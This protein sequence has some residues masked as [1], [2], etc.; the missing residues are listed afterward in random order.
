MAA[1]VSQ[2]AQ[3]WPEDKFSLFLYGTLLHPAVLKRVIGHEGTGLFHQPALLYDFTRHHVKGDTYPAILPW[4]KADKLFDQ[5][6]AIPKPSPAERC[7]RGSLV[8]G[9]SRVDIELLD[10]FEGD[11]YE[12]QLVSAIPLGPSQP[13]NVAAADAGVVFDPVT[14]P[15]K[16]SEEAIASQTKAHVYVWNKSPLLE[17][18]EPDI[19]SYETFVKENL[20]RWI[21]NEADRSSYTD[22]DRR[23]EKFEAVIREGNVV[24][25]KAA[26]VI[27]REE[28]ATMVDYPGDSNANADANA[29]EEEYKFGHTMLKYWGF[30]QGYINLNNG[31][32]GSPPRPVIEASHKIWEKIEGNPDLFH[33]INMEKELLAVR[34]RIAKFINAAGPDEVVMIPN[35]THGVNTVLHNIHW[36][37][38]DIL[39]GFTT[40]YGGIQSTLRRYAD[41]DPKPNLQVITLTFPTTPQAIIT[42]LRNHLLNLERKPTSN[43]VALIDGI[44]SVPGA[45]LP[46]EDLVRVCKEFGVTSVVDAAHVMGQ[47]PLDVQRA[48]PDFLVSNCH[49]WLYSKRPSAILYVPKRNHDKIRWTFPISW[50]YKSPPETVP[51]GELFEWTGTIDYTPYLSVN[52]A[53]D[54]REKIGGEKRIQDYCHRVARDGG[55]RMAQILGTKLMDERDEFTACMVDVMLPYPRQASSKEG[56]TIAIGIQRKLLQDWHCISSVYWHD[57]FLW[58]RGSGQIW[59]EV[60][61]F[62]YVARALLSIC[63]TL[64]EGAEKA[65]ADVKVEEQVE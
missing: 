27:L 22:V 38:E 53:L 39:I 29:A 40:T 63:Q 37:S 18:L 31:S 20:H 15:P 30:E 8:T 13:L 46:W 51:L 14:Y 6:G 7:V 34:T 50:S 32:Y 56:H 54:F 49:K 21:G 41:A 28:T 43:V 47:I 19:W 45:R 26:D 1:T 52:A 55:K 36:K 65:P 42:L 17:T 12:R 62:E 44:I 3:D 64:L 57:E 4:E 25:M 24:D 10:V 2:S 48:E 35:T 61:D 60:S 9:F 16:D 11:E 33:R 59:L 58:T 5:T 23:R